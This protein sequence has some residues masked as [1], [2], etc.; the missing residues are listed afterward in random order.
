MT[1]CRGQLWTAC[2]Q[3]SKKQSC[4]WGNS[5]DERAS[6]RRSVENKR[7][8]EKQCADH[9]RKKERDCSVLRSPEACRQMCCLRFIKYE[10]HDEFVF[11]CH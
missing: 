11:L 3:S 2:S 8:A 4:L 7:S 9:E 1:Y 5:F 6:D 10:F